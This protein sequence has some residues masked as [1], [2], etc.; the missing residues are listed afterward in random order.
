MSLSQPQTRLIKDL[1]RFDTTSVHSNLD[2]ITYVANYLDGSGANVRL[3]HNHDGSK[4]N[5]LATIGPQTQA[6]GIILSGHTDTVP[7]TGQN[8]RTNPYDITEENGKLY[9]RGSA[10]MKVFCALALAEFDG[11]ARER[12]QD[13]QRPLHLLLTYDEE[14][15]CF[16]AKNWVKTYGNQL[17][18]PDLVLVGEPTNMRAAVAHKGIRCF[19][20]AVKGCGGHSSNPANGISAI[21]HTLDFLA[22]VRTVAEQFRQAGIQDLRFE[23]PHTTVNLGTINGGS[24]VNVIPD[25]CRFSFETR[26]VPGH[27][28]QDLV[29]ALHRAFKKAREETGGRLQIDI[30]ETVHTLPF[31]GDEHHHGTQFLL[32]QLK[33]RQTVVVPFCTEASAYQE[34]GWNTVVCGPGDIAQAHQPDEFI[35]T[36]QAIHGAQLIH[37]VAQRCFT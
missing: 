1:I 29:D 31:A 20:A 26:P 14:L 37:N 32:R 4:A 2:L 18:P 34:N 22:V 12:A 27:S 9:A 25:E 6:G 3:D 28:G 5:L 11:I 24:A 15:G 8:W 17:E 21:E 35:K 36:E 19:N 33:D 30:E 13:L 7:V 10:D 23:P 16:G